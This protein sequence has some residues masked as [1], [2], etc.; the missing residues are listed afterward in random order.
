[1]ERFF[2]GFLKTGIVTFIILIVALTIWL[3]NIPIRHLSDG[4][5]MGFGFIYGG[6]GAA[7]VSVFIG[8]FGGMITC[9]M[10]DD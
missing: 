9:L 4:A 6:M 7:V 1:M 10:V 2:T 5:G 3:V 8:L